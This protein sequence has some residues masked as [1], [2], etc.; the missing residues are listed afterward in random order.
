MIV[1]KLQL[2]QLKDQAV[3]PR[4]CCVVQECCVAEV[5]CH[6]DA[7]VQAGKVKRGHRLLVEAC[8]GSMT[9]SK[10]NTLVS[11][12]VSDRPLNKDMQATQPA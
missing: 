8:S 5:V 1:C 10:Q 4:T 3:K 7:G 11:G 9:R 12:W 6:H 2:L